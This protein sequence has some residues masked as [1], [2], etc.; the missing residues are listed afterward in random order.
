MYPSAL[1]IPVSA[2]G[3]SVAHHFMGPQ[4]VMHITQR[5]ADKIADFVK[6]PAHPILANDMQWEL[7]FIERMQIRPWVACFE[8]SCAFSVWLSCHGQRSTIRLG[9]RV[10]NGIFMMHAWVESKDE[11]FFYDARFVPIFEN[12]APYCSAGQ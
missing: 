11:K 12:A 2:I 4:K 8:T 10:E 1:F 5:V 7:Q 6:A 9:K 3:F